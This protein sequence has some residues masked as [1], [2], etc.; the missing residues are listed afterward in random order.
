M[1]QKC[2]FG[3]GEVAFEDNQN[4]KMRMKKLKLK[5]FIWTTFESTKA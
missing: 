5:N 1:A 3:K 4:E 2:I